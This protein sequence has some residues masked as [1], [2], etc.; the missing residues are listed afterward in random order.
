MVGGL[1]GV[2][3][4]LGPRARQGTCKGTQVSCPPFQSA[5]T[6]VSPSDQD[7]QL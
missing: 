6:Q 3:P 7:Q 1:P 5:L 2:P 4:S